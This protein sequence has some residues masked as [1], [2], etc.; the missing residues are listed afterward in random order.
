MANS[1]ALDASDPQP[2]NPSILVDT[3]VWRNY[4]RLDRR[5]YEIINRLMDGGRICCLDLGVG[6]LLMSAR[7]S[8]EMKVFQ[9]FT[10][11]FPVLQEPPGAWVEAARLFFQVRR[12]FPRLSLRDCYIAVVAKTNQVQLYTTNQQLKR[13][14][15]SFGIPIYS[16]RVKSI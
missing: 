14:G 8:K 12:K 15:R 2:S 13:L 6:E 4:F 16:D 5:T 10:Q 7:N 9:D 3:P 11:V 1:K